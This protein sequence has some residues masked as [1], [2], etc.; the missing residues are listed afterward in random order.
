M[1]THKVRK[2]L[3]PQQLNWTSNTMASRYFVGAGC[4]GPHHTLD[5][6]RPHEACTPVLTTTVNNQPVF[7][8]C[9]G[10]NMKAQ[11]CRSCLIALLPPLKTD[12]PSLGGCC[13]S[14]SV[15]DCSSSH[16]Q[17]RGLAL[18]QA[19]INRHSLHTTQ[20]NNSSSNYV[21]VCC[22]SSISSEVSPRLAVLCRH[23]DG[24][25]GFG[26]MFTTLTPTQCMCLQPSAWGSPCQW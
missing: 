24:G 3:A 17:S 1:A 14:L 16:G 26:S 25:C 19:T 6:I 18:A 20:R 15:L 12:G 13:P 8:A 4:E 9:S 2:S 5:L 7:M 10:A 11:H 23:S 21:T 22:N